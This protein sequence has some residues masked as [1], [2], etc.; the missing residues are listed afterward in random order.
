ML[1]LIRS[2]VNV[3]QL[4]KLPLKQSASRKLFGEWW[5]CKLQR[6][7]ARLFHK[8][9]C[10]KHQIHRYVRHNEHLS[11]DSHSQKCFGRGGGGFLCNSLLQAGL[12]TPS[13]T[14]LLAQRPAGPRIL[15][16]FSEPGLSRSKA[17]SLNTKPLAWKA[18]EAPML[19]A[20]PLSQAQE[21]GGWYP[22]SMLERVWRG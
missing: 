11:T 14:T 1:G 2:K 17:R 9:N 4:R 5:E 10:S 18:C 16:P 6:Q 3:G 20:A 21:Q 19:S 12:A 13:P 15:C 7:E 22:L 8:G